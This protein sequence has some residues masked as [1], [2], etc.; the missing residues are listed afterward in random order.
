MD[1]STA[2]DRLPEAYAAVLCLQTKARRG[3]MTFRARYSIQLLRGWLTLDIIP[4]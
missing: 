3:H 2:I 1:R 4:A